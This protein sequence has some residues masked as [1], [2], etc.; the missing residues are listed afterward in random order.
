MKKSVNLISVILCGTAAVV[1]I[2]NAILHFTIPYSNPF[3]QFLNTLC[4]LLWCVAFV[5][6]LIRY[7]N[8]QK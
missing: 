2:I 7:K 8:G 4:A 6:N 5:V 1:W 3:L